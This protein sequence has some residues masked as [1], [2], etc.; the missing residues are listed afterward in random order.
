MVS[1]R[2][3]AE[4]GGEQDRGILAARRMAWDI[5]PDPPHVFQVCRLALRLFDATATLHRLGAKE[6]RILHAAALLHDV[7][8]TIDVLRHHKHARDLILAA[9]LPGFSD[10]EK[11]VIACV[12]RYH[13]KAHPS[14]GHRLYR[15]LGR[16][17]RDRVAKLAA[18][19]RIAD[20][21]DR[22][23]TASVRSLRV[24]Q[25]PNQLVVRVAQRRPSSLD[26]WGGLRKRALFEEVF[27]L[28][29]QIVAEETGLQ[30]N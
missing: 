10:R 15:D 25:Q 14:P 18:I 24:E 19:L 11:E 2:K 23:H 22:C 16:K 21:L 30:G 13:R 6:R 27:G 26:I 12:A 3:N 17:D 5:D 20:G 1:Q 4:H 28:Q 7:G 29:V 8:H 9:K